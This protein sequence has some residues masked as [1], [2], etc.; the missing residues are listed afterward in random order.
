MLILG[1]IF[2]T[3][4]ICFILKLHI[5][6]NVFIQNLAKRFKTVL[7]GLLR[8]LSI[9]IFYCFVLF[10]HYNIVHIHFLKFITLSSAVS[11]TYRISL[12]PWELV[13]DLIFFASEF[14]NNCD[15]FQISV[16][17][18]K[19]TPY[20]VSKVNYRNLNSFLLILL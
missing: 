14:M 6:L 11:E 20:F 19:N 4:I 16:T 17:R 7:Y 10:C 12:M 13:P 18:I 5:L 3:F 1:L 15:D 9:F 8:I 2:I